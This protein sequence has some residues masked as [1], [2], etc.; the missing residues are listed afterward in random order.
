MREILK[1]LEGSRHATDRGCRPC[2]VIRACRGMITVIGDPRGVVDL[3]E[4]PYYLDQ[5]DGIILVSCAQALADDDC[6]I[7]EDGYW[8]HG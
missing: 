8:A 6:G 2:L 4:L 1:V 5:V 7:D 3:G